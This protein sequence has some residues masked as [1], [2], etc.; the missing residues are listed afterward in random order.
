MFRNVY[1]DYKFLKI[2]RFLLKLIWYKYMVR[3]I[4]SITFKTVKFQAGLHITLLALIIF[5]NTNILSLCMSN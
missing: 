1:F 4:S 3:K 5:V 2:C